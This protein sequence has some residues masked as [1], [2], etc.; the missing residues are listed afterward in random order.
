MAVIEP[1]KL[2]QVAQELFVAA[3]VPEEDAKI[4]ARLCVGANLAGHDSHGVIQIPTYIDRIERGHINPKASYDV[5]KETP[6]TTVV[7]GNWGI[8]YVVTQRLM[9]TT[10]EKAKEQLSTSQLSISEIAYNLGF[11]YPTSFNKLFKRKT[12]MSPLEFRRKFN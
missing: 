12:E 4:F 11:E 5:V 9:K 7:D 1:T 2:R 8:G 10:I 6:T 3:N